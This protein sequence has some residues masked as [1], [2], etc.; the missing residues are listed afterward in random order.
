MIALDADTMSDAAD[1]Y[2][3]RIYCSAVRRVGISALMHFE[4]PQQTA[5]V[6]VYSVLQ[7]WRSSSAL[8]GASSP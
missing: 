3:D 4:R 1:Y 5:L 2:E 6:F 8:S 7:P